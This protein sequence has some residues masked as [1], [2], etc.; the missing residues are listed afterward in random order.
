MLKQFVA[1]YEQSLKSRQSAQGGLVL[2]A[3]GIDFRRWLKNPRNEGEAQVGDAKTIKVT[4]AADVAQV[5]ADL[6]KIAEKASQP[7][8]RG[9]PRPAAADAAAEAA[10]HRGAEGPQ[11]HRLHGRRRPDPAPAHRHRR[12][13]GHRV[14]GRR[15]AA[16]GHHLHQG[17]RR[18]R[19][20]KAPAN[21]RSF[22]ELLKALDAAG[23]AD[24]GL[25]GAQG[26]DPA[27]KVPSGTANNVDKYA[28]CIEDAEGDRAKARKCAELLSGS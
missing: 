6:D 1:G 10:R 14:Q 23:F 2:G 27:P 9:R 12:P 19:Q 17:R 21:P 5:I 28:A 13:Q 4:G 25:G 18:T 22:T 15:G 11:R 8:G 26:G 3:L 7:A 16:A 24:L 20:F